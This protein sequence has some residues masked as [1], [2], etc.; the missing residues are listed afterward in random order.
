MEVHQPA[1]HRGLATNFKLLKKIWLGT[2]L[3]DMWRRGSCEF[4]T[5]PGV[6]YSPPGPETPKH[7]ISN[8]YL[9]RFFRSPNACVSGR[10]LF[11]TIF[12]RDLPIAPRCLGPGCRHDPMT[13]LAR[14]TGAQRGR[15]KVGSSS[16][17][18]KHPASFDLRNF[19]T[20]RP[21]IQG[22]E[23]E[24]PRIH[25]IRLQCTRPRDRRRS[26]RPG[27]T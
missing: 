11:I 23:V 20:A 7:P 3:G 22:A 21:R 19:Q 6:C 12:L 15:R 24:T 18:H 14:S 27:R 25:P 9:D 16:L 17:P 2:A 4:Y 1:R 10:A 26:T 8:V 5:S 13:H